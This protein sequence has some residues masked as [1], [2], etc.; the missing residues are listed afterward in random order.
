M[1]KIITFGQTR[2]HDTLL[3]NER[4]MYIRTYVRK[5]ITILYA[6]CGQMCPLN[7][8]RLQVNV[9]ANTPVSRSF[10]DPFSINL[11]IQM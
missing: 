5:Y 7:V 2:L 6:T 4:Y 1:F 10:G 8:L 11:H 9:F 3:T